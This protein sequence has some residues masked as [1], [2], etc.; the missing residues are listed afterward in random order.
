MVDKITDLNEISFLLGW[1]FRIDPTAF[2]IAVWRF[3]GTA[4]KYIGTHTC[5][6]ILLPEDET[7]RLDSDRT[8]DAVLGGIIGGL[9]GA[10]LIT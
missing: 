8:I 6:Y 3:S 4:Y 1:T 2:K 5:I 7:L 10:R 9:V